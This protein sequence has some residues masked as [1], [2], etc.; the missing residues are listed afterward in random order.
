M[1]WIFI[2]GNKWEYLF[3]DAISFKFE[4]KKITYVYFV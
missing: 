2:Y 1:Y 4:W 3:N